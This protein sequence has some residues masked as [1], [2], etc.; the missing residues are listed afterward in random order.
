MYPLHRPAA[1]VV[2]VL[3]GSVPGES[4]GGGAGDAGNARYAARGAF[5]GE[6]LFED[7]A[8]EVFFFVLWR[9]DREAP[10]GVCHIG[11]ADGLGGHLL[12]RVDPAVADAVGELFFLA[13]G[14]LRGEHAGKGLAEDLFLDHATGAH[15]GFGSEAHG[16]VEKL[17][18]EE[19][20][21]AFHAPG[22]QALVGTE[23]VIHIEF[24]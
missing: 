19:R 6:V 24:A 22:T 23:A 14:D 18:V 20:N 15:L 3:E 4:F 10:G 9:V 7:G 17:L 12:Q 16:Y 21:A 5:A 2:H 13:P 1:G 8:V 11:V